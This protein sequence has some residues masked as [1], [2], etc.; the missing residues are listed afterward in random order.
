MTLN[1]TNL[2]TGSRHYG[3]KSS[4]TRIVFIVLAVLL[5]LTPGGV[6]LGEE[7]ADKTLIVYYSRTGKSKLVCDVL[8][9]NMHA[10]ILEVKDTE[11]YYKPGRLGYYTA[12]FNS[13]LNRYTPIETELKNFSPYES[14][15]IVSPVWNWKLSVPIRAFIQQ[16]RFEGKKMIFITTANNEVTKYE[17]YGDDAPFMKRFFRDYLRKKCA[18]MKSFVKSSGCEISGY[19]HVPTLEKTDAQ[20]KEKILSFVDDLKNRL[21]L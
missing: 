16:N 14:I 6:A 12:G 21:L 18:E 11:G 17:Q 9:K 15:I 10:D 1:Q 5:Q 2:K 20:I 4:V 3:I 13:V 19:Y 7:R 8:Q